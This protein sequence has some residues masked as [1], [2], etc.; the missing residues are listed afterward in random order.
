ML[1]DRTP[2]EEAGTVLLAPETGGGQQNVSPSLSP[3]GRYVAFLSERD[4]FSIDL[5]LADARTGEIIRTISSA[6]SDPHF[7]ALRFIDSS[8]TWAPDGS[9][10]AFV[11][12][13]NGDNQLVTVRTE[14]GSVERRYSVPGVG[15]IQNPAWSPDGEAIVFTGLHGGVSDLFRLDVESGTVTQLTDDKHA[16]FQP[17]W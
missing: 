2:P 14:D 4:L 17:S 15:A 10:L 6:A 12:F 16:D 13:A 1:E 7:D 9:R 3:D 8:V 5:S 11:V